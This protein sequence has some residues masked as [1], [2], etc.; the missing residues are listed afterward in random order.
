MLANA[1]KDPGPDGL[2]IFNIGYLA[3][4]AGLLLAW[5]S[6]ILIKLTV[7][8]E[9]IR[10]TSFC[11]NKTLESKPFYPIIGPIPFS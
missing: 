5:N 2:K 11:L 10:Y 9:Y 3:G 8:D 7:S 4:I 1:H 6:T